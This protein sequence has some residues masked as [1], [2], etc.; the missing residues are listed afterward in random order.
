M[1]RAVVGPAVR[2]DLR[3]A[4]DAL[5]G[6]VHAHEPGSDESAGGCQHGPAKQALEL[7]GRAQE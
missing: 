6:G 5:A 3:D 2:F 7:V 1:R 4:G